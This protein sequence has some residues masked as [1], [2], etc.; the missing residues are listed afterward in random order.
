MYVPRAPGVPLRLSQQTQ[1]LATHC[2]DII[3][4]RLS[5]PLFA[6]S[7]SLVRSRTMLRIL[8][9]CLFLCTP[10]SKRRPTLPASNERKRTSH[11]KKAVHVPTKSVG[12]LL[13]VQVGGT[14]SLQSNPRA[15]KAT[16]CAGDDINHGNAW[17]EQ[18]VHEIVL[19]LMLSPSLPMTVTCFW[20]TGFM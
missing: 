15:S 10:C 7:A 1:L 20:P 8:A 13:L 16:A 14:P 6:G 17:F 5:S 19:T 18:G 12:D 9:T 2:L 4:R 3:L 11:R